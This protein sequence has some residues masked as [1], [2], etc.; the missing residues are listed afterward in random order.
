MV[1]FVG[2]LA[3]AALSLVLSVG[4]ATSVA[5]EVRGPDVS[6]HQHPSGYTIN[7]ASARI[8][9]AEFG[10]VKATEG[11]TYTNPYFATDFAELSGSQLVR[12]AYHYARPR[13]G[14]EDAVAQANHFVAV[15]GPLDTVGDLPPVLDLERNDGLTPTELIAWTDAYL[16]EVARLTGRTPIIYTYPAFW[17][18]SMADTTIF[19]HYPLWI[20]TYGPQPMLVGGWTDYTFWQYTDKEPL[21]GM[22]APVDMSVFKGTS[23]DLAA[24]ADPLTSPLV[25]PT[26]PEITFALSA[27]TVRVGSSV[28]LT[29][30][31][32]GIPAGETV[33][34]QGYWS[35]SWHTWDTTQISATGA[36]SFTIR[37]TNKAVNTY[38]VYVAPTADHPAI[39]SPSFTLR[40][41]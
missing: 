30:I 39:A 40:A 8:A 2:G 17:R 29:G 28:T 37:P 22:S 27:S 26:E 23:A 38:R 9:G 21:A 14:V 12:G 41:E 16:T 6:S 34:R 19:N 33:Y 32:L 18:S 11:L 4:F 1:R 7:W 31:A 13:P 20:A 3:S 35:G 24:L 36:Y 15:T 25:E 5:A 10:F